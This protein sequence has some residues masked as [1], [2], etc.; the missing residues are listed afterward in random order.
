VY[1]LDRRSDGFKRFVTFLMMISVKAKSDCLS[2][3]L[4]IIDEPD[5]GLH[6][7]G[8]QFL[9]EELKKI[10]KD[11]IVVIATHSIFM[12][13]KDRIDR[14]LIVKK[15]K[16]ETKIISDYASKMLDEEVIYKALGYSLFDLLKKRNVIF[17]GWN[18]KYAFQCWLSSTSVI[19]KVKNSWKNIGMIHA[20]GAKDVQRV[21]AHLENFDREYLVL[22][23]ADK[24]AL[25]WQKKF[26]GKYQWVTYK[27]LGFKDKETI[28]DFLDDTYVLDRVFGVLK[29]EQLDAGVSFEGCLTFNS[30]ME[31]LKQTIGAGKEEMDRLKRLI[32]N[33]I[34][35]N[36]PPKRI[37]LTKLVDVIDIASDSRFHANV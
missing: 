3:A 34:F 16:E 10:S 4:I 6:P 21:A 1:S 20:F 25:D 5:I 24:P 12:I 26:E 17:E 7:S 13:D 30:K 33:S 11:N 29:K 32:K 9:R 2:D 37:G 8:I 23:D 36:I 27:D 35:N 31:K 18:D 28:E 15:E 19:T 22:S 14:H